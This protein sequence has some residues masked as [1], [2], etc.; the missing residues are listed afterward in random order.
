MIVKN[1]AGQLPRLAESL[2]GQIDHATIV[3]TGSTDDT[4]TVAQ[5]VFSYVP[6]TMLRSEW[7]GYGPCR[8]VA[9][10]AAEPY[11][12]WLLHMD[13]DETLEG[14]IGELPH[15]VETDAFDAQTH[16]GPLR[17]WTPRLIASGR[18]WRWQRRAHEYL[19]LGGAHRVHTHSFHVVHHGDGG[20]RADKLERELDL[21]NKDW[22]EL[23]D[24]RT[25]FY[26]S[27]TYD[28]AGKYQDARG[29]YTRRLQM[30]GWDEEQFYSTYRLGVC[31]LRLGADDEGCGVLWRAWGMRPHRLEPLVALAEH[32]RTRAEWAPMWLICEQAM[33]LELGLEDDLFV[34]SDAGWR[35]IYEASIAAWYTDQKA[36]G[37]WCIEE[38]EKK[39]DLP[40]PYRSSVQSNAVFYRT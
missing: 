13:A 23:E 33:K 10:E 37:R 24:P 32:Y 29:W 38:L 22:E 12:D 28:D 4:E 20:N 27:R 40:E 17:Y 3:D 21:L 5:D 18:G 16:Y 35:I 30:A 25:A 15:S 2:K 8:N 9:L 31:L 11:T 34:D 7:L 19:E 36:I 39:D 14:E 1:E 26:L 6:K